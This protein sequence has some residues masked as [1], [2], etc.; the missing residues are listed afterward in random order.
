MP[1]V[2]HFNTDLPIFRERITVNRK[3]YVLDF[4]WNTRLS[5]WR[6]T[7]SKPGVVE[8]LVVDRRVGNA[9]MVS[10]DRDGLL[11]FVG[12]EPYTQS[13]FLNRQL[14]MEVATTEEID[15]YLAAQPADPLPDLTYG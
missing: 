9:T 12:G 8:P 11:C 14:Y 10:L 13:A 3:I 2:Y 1:D 7:V 5:D 6:I 15:A 4:E